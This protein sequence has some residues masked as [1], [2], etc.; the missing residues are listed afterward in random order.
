MDSPEKPELTLRQ[1]GDAYMEQ[2]TKLF[3]ENAVRYEKQAALLY[4]NGVLLVPVNSTLV[5]YYFDGIGIGS[6]VSHDQGKNFSECLS[7]HE[8]GTSKVDNVENIKWH[9]AGSEASSTI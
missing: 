9:F 2:V 1:M 3:L 4:E 8:L 7:W 6:K 5:K